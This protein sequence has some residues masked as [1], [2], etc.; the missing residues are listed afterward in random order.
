MRQDVAA[1][2]LQKYV[3]GFIGGWYESE[4]GRIAAVVK[5]DGAQVEELLALSDRLSI[6][7]S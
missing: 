1:R 7:R 4:E 5:V 3:R 6:G 2:R